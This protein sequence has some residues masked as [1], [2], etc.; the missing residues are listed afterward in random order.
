M[1]KFVSCLM[2]HVEKAR[3]VTSQTARGNHSLKKRRDW[4]VKERSQ[5]HR[6][7]FFRMTLAQF[8]YLDL[9]HNVEKSLDAL[10]GPEHHP[11]IRFTH[12]TY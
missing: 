11:K 10:F 4:L 3:A 6:L 9:N 5:K 1:L 12:R 8:R 7:I 2:T